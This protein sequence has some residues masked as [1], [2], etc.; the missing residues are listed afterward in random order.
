MSAPDPARPHPARVPRRAAG[1]GLAGAGWA[2]GAT[3]L[4]AEAAGETLTS[5]RPAAAP[6][7]R[8]AAD[9]ARRPP[10][11]ARPLRADPAGRPGRD[12]PGHDDRGVGLRR[13]LPRPDARAAPRQPYHGAGPQRAAGAHLHPPARRRHPGR[14][15]RVPDRPGGG[16]GPHVPAVRRH[17]ARPPRP[18]GVDVPLRRE[19]LRLPGR[20]ARGHAL[21]P[22]PPHGLHRPA[23]VARPRRVRDRARRRGGRAAAAQGRAGHPAVHLRPG[24]RGGR[25][26]PLPVA[27][28]HPAGTARR[29]GRVHGGR[30]GRRDPGQRRPLA[31]AGGGRPRGTGCGCSTGRT[32]GGTGSSSPAARGSCRSAATRGCSPRRS[33]TPR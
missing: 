13:R 3:L 22:R 5:A 10:G 15:R 2:L 32:P 19:G 14:L 21:V 18:G 9:P 28:P 27:R 7:H 25:L 29:R 4:P 16:G 33:S 20:A 6:V 17:E 26:V 23:G 31:G 30:A 12:H 1:T 11:R 24:V 8:A